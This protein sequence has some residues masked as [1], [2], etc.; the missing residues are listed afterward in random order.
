[1]EYKEG[2][3]GAAGRGVEWTSGMVYRVVPWGTLLSPI[4]KGCVLVGERFIRA[5]FTVGSAASE[6][7]NKNTVF[8]QPS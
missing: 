4:R 2:F 5:P 8:S 7:K 1:M 6:C 3:D